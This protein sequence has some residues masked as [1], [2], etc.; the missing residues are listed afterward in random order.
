MLKSYAHKYEGK[1][2]IWIRESKYICIGER[3][4]QS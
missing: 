1:Y 4:E 2:G 3:W